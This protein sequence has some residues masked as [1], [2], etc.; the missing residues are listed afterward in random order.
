MKTG[1]AVK[2]RADLSRSRQA[3]APVEAGRDPALAAGGESDV[4]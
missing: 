1:G 2:A 4:P 3:E